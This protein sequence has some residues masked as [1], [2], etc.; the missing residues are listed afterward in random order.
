MQ[1]TKGTS[2]M[3]LKK[4]DAALLLKNAASFENI[5]LNRVSF[6]SS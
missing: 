5:E 2:S 3:R 1:K 4:K 6:F